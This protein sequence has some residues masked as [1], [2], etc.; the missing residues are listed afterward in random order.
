MFMPS[1][2]DFLDD[3]AYPDFAKDFNESRGLERGG[4]RIELKK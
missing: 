2:I 1:G 4:T 3:E